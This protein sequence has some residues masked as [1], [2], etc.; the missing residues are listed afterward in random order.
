MR[1]V[2][3]LRLILPYGG[4]LRIG[5]GVLNIHFPVG[6][7]SPFLAAALIIAACC[8][9]VDALN[10][11]ATAASRAAMSCGSRGTKRFFHLAQRGP[12][13]RLSNLAG[14]IFRRVRDRRLD[15]FGRLT[16]NKR[17][18]E[19]TARFQ[20]RFFVDLFRRAPGHQESL[21]RLMNFG[22]GGFRAQIAAPQML[23][24]R[25]EGLNSRLRGRIV[26][27]AGNGAY[28]GQRGAG[29]RAEVSD[30]ASSAAKLCIPPHAGEEGATT[31]L[32][33]CEIYHMRSVCGISYVQRCSTAPAGPRKSWRRR[34]GRR[35]SGWISVSDLAGFWI[36]LPR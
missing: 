25:D 26:I 16:Q 13:P 3:S 10:F 36:L 34:R 18:V 2:A 31:T 28:E 15:G 7:R 11:A 6:W 1:L 21:L 4:R 12:T 9:G 23:K 35:K 32:T 30:L 19:H 8:S 20:T 14:F 17:A 33:V 27:D 5:L 29:P 24:R 22:H